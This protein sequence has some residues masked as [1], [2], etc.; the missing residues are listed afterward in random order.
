LPIDFIQKHY[1]SLDF[2]KLSSNPAALPLIY[3]YPSS[4]HWNWFKVI[5]NKGL[6]YNQSTFDFLFPFYKIYIKSK[7]KPPVSDNYV[8]LSFIH[9]VFRDFPGD[10]SFFLQEKFTPFIP[11]DILSRKDFLKLDFNFIDTYKA[12]LNFH[13][14]SLS[15]AIKDC[16]TPAFIIENKNLFDW[17]GVSFYN[18]PLTIELVINHLDDINFFLLANCEKFDWNWSFI[19]EYV[20]GFS[21]FRLSVNESIYKQLIEIP[22]SKDEIFSILQKKY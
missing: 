17:D 13:N 21:K 1:E 14:L 22:L 6:V 16:I 8:I 7:L 9:N 4:K 3:K 10:L 19:E 5:S 20:Y 12:K 2:F 18:L 15:Y 11:W